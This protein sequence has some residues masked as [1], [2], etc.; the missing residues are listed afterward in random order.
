MYKKIYRGR[1]N[2]NCFRNLIK[3]I[4]LYLLNRPITD[5][6]HKFISDYNNNKH[7][8]SKIFII[9]RAN[10]MSLVYDSYI[11]FEEKIMLS[12]N[13][14]SMGDMNYLKNCNDKIIDNSHKIIINYSF[15]WHDT[16]FI[17]EISHDEAKKE[18]CD[19]ILSIAFTV[20]DVIITRKLSKRPDGHLTL[21]LTYKK[22]LELIEP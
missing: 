15:D 3:N 19:D 2:E 8:I 20:N 13:N 10:N 18:I 21:W 7:D 12:I 14:F 6:V 22:Y 11:N 16:P 1:Y 5:S 17:H 9:T 4:S